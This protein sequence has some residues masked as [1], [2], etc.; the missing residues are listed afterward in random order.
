[1]ASFI[2]YV[3]IHDKKHIIKSFY[4]LVVKASDSEHIKSLKKG[5]IKEWMRVLSNTFYW[6]KVKYVGRRTCLGCL[7]TL[8]KS[9]VS[10]G[11]G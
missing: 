1:M 10:K 7:P 5:F 2:A 6:K 11:K 4:G 8:G 9:S 3:L